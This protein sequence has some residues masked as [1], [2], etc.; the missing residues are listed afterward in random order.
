VERA[1]GLNPTNS[2]LIARFARGS[3]SR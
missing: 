3:K 1:G 2:S